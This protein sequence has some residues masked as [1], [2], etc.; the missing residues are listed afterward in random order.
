MERDPSAQL[1]V[2]DNNDI[3]IDEFEDF[4][5]KVTLTH[6]IVTQ[7]MMSLQ[8]MMTLSNMI[9]LMLKI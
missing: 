4:V 9:L 2:E 1:F 8:K 5:M 3:N 6:L 7:V